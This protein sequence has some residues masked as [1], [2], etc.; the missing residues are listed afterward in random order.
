MIDYKLCPKFE[1][2]FELLG[3]KWTGLIIETMLNEK[4]SFT[5]ILSSIPNMSAKMLTNR[6]KELEKEGIITRNV[7]AETPVKIEYLLTKKGQELEK[8]MVEVR[9]WGEKWL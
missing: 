8:V 9:I 1:Y 5:E 2:A 3:K 4:K 7:Y 6:L